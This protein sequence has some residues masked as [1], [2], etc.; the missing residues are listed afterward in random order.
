MILD[1]IGNADSYRGMG[2]R[3]ARALDYLRQADLKEMPL[4]RHDVEGDDLFLL[5]QEYSTKD[6]AEG[7]IEA[8]RLFMDVQY[9]V[10]GSEAL[11]YA[12]ISVLTPEPYD[13]DKD[14]QFFQGHAETFT[15]QA[16]MFAVL[17]P[18]DGHM[19]GLAL[20]Q[21]QRVR[22]AVVKIRI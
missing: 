9:V 14:L 19:P 16:G 5:L 13:A 6:P 21:P 1:V 22:K 2:P 18:Q 12:D 17:L 11:G 3:L 20:D 15:L 8:H 7:R 10:C 4:G